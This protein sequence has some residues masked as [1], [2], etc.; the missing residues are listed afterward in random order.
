MKSH[1]TLGNALALIS[2]LFG[3]ICTILL[4]VGMKEESRVDMQLFFG[5][6]GLFSILFLWPVGLILNLMSAEIFELPHTKQALYAIIT[7]V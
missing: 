1:A 2:A 3:A 7:N 5:F 4:K 6:V